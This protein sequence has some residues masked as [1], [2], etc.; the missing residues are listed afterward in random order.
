MAFLHRAISFQVVCL[1]ATWSSAVFAEDGKVPHGE[2][3]AAQSVEPSDATD[4]AAEDDDAEAH[5]FSL[6]FEPIQLAFGRLWVNGEFAITSKWS[7]GA[8]AGVA[9]APTSVGDAGQ[10]TV[11]AQGRYYLFGDFDHGLPLAL[12]VQYLGLDDSVVAAIPLVGYKY[13]FDFG[14][15]LEALLGM[16]AGYAIDEGDVERIGAIQVGAGWSF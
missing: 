13:I 6:L 3:E 8:K 12:S 10:F 1:A 4:D 9:F 15:T 16:G 14:L 11:G 7:V 5:R 2:S